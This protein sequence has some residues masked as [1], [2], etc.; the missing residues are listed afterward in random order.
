MAHLPAFLISIMIIVS[1]CKP[2]RSTHT[3]RTLGGIN[4]G[5]ART[6]S[7]PQIKSTQD[8]TPDKNPIPTVA[9]IE[10]EE[11]DHPTL[12]F[13]GKGTVSSDGKNYGVI[14]T[15]V[16]T[17]STT[18]ISFTITKFNSSGGYSHADKVDQAVRNETGTITYALASKT[19]LKE[20]ESQG[21]KNVNYLFFAE[22]VTRRDGKTLT[23]SSPLPVMI[24]PA[25]KS[26]YERLAINTPLI[27]TAVATDDL[28]SF[29]VTASVRKT[30]EQ[31]NNLHF[32]LTLTPADEQRGAAY[33]RLATPKISKY[34]VDGVRK[35]LMVIDYDK[36]NK[37]SN[38]KMEHLKMVYKLCSSDLNGQIETF[39]CK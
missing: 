31:G 39:T 27:Y 5:L 15:L 20:L 22:K 23:L 25:P 8:A 16:S 38:N 17:S 18:S 21:F 35:K 13:D 3:S 4:D 29:N 6:K 37:S 11:V 30:M 12:N 7:G 36:P 1:A 2:E 26:R 33:D 9:P 10:E 28:G 24:I 34:T 14:Q 32:E 19:R